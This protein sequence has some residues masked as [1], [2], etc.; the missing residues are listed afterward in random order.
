MQ[1]IV[2]P[3]SIR[4]DLTHEP[5]PKREPSKQALAQIFR[6]R[7]VSHPFEI[8]A[9]DVILAERFDHMNTRASSDLFN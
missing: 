7:A 5:Q 1:P 6:G 2:A 3:L 4:D 8:D 9:V